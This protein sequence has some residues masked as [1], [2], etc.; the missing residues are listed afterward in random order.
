MQR[1]TVTF[2]NMIIS[3]IISVIMEN[4]LRTLYLEKNR[5][6]NFSPIK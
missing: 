6:Q 1:R 5:R 3:D 4:K 2:N